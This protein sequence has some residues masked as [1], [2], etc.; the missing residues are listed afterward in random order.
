MRRYSFFLNL[1]IEYSYQVLLG[2]QINYSSLLFFCLKNLNTINFY[3]IHLC[4]LFT[5]RAAA[6][7]IWFGFVPVLKLTLFLTMRP[8][9]GRF[10]W[11]L[12]TFLLLFALLLALL[13]RL[14]AFMLLRDR[15]RNRPFRFFCTC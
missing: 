15:E 6:F 1:S 8:V 9:L 7:L 12:L 11:F 2:S 4:N 5:L 14:L 13:F 10:I 3:D